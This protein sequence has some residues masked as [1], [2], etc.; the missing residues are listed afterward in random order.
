[1]RSA[2]LSEEVNDNNEKT[3]MLPAVSFSYRWNILFTI[4]VASNF[5]ISATLE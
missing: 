3:L 1:M 5:K 2:E 4:F